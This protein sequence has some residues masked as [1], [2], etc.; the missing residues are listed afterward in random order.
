VGR[1][2][3]VYSG[4]TYALLRRMAR[5]QP[6]IE[7]ILNSIAMLVDGPFKPALAN[8]AGPWTGSSGQRVLQPR[9]ALPSL[10]NK[11]KE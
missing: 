10:W 5:R 7:A 11:Q 3:L 4:Y 9:P 2:I 8:Q 1:H 6:V